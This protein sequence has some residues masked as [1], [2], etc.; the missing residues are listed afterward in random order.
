MLRVIRRARQRLLVNELFS[1][2]ANAVGVALL[3]VIFLLL[4][5]T[6]MVQWQWLLPAP[7]LALAAGIYLALKRLPTPYRTAQIVDRRMGLADT[8]STAWFFGRKSGNVPAAVLQ[9]QQDQAARISE[10]LDIARAIPFRLPRRAYLVGVLALLAGS[11]FALRYGVM[12]KLDLHPPLARMLE[13]RLGMQQK[14]TLAEAVKPPPAPGRSEDSNE[15]MA[16]TEQ[17]KKSG[18][19][20][21]SDEKDQ[22]DSGDSAESRPDSSKSKDAKAQNDSK[23]GE[24]S[25]SDQDDSQDQ[26][27]NSADS[28]TGDRSGQQQQGQSNQNR[29]PNSQ[30][31]GDGSSENSS[32]LSKMKDA[33]QNLMSRVNPAQNNSGAQQNA[34]QNGKKNSKDGQNG[35][36]QQA[37]K[38]GRRGDGNR[39]GDS[40]EGQPGDQAGNSADSQGEPGDKSDGPQNSKQ[41]GNG[42]GNRD[43]DKAIKEAEQ[44]A[45]MGKISEII[46]KR[47]ANLTGEATVEVQSTKQQ[48]QT[49]YAQRGAQHTQ[50]GAEINRD[51]IPVGLEGYVEKYFEQV[52]K[53]ARK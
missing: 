49:P 47:S 50:G 15:D 3:A 40:K 31:D 19:P 4:I 45:A 9:G 8:L 6:E 43:G 22:D 44:L 25:E 46:G 17:Q 35:G 51:E 24:Q 41:P 1:Q 10:T 13:D 39:Q 36:K 53:Q 16:N 7:A 21:A 20:G 23:S 29:Q 52:Q 28:K 32:L 18:E 30:R 11:L 33:L 14:V 12:N 38:D 27:E 37:G 34:E 5:G 42:I 2:A 26:A 48:L